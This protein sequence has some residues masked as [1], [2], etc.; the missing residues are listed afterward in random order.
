MR[1]STSDRRNGSRGGRVGTVAWRDRDRCDVCGGVE[2]LA[3]TGPV[4]RVGCVLVVEVRQLD[5]GWRRERLR[6]GCQPL[7]TRC[8]WFVAGVA[9]ADGFKE[10][11][12]GGYG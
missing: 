12:A 8:C 5:A 10:D 9:L 6:S 4:A 11:Y 1:R 3:R 7:A 2:F